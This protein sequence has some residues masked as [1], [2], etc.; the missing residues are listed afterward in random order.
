MTRVYSDIIS[1]IDS[2]RHTLAVYLDLSSAF[3]SI[4]HSILLEELHS[5]GIR[6]KALE[7]LRSYLSDRLV[8]V[9][10][11]GKRSEPLPLKYGVPQGSVLG[12]VLFVLYTRRLSAIL[13]DLG[14]DH[15]IYADDTQFYCSFNDDEIPHIKE[16]VTEALRTIQTWMCSMKLKLN[17]SKTSF[18]I[19]SP[20]HKR[21]FITEHFGDL[22]IGDIRLS[23]SSQVKTLGVTLDSELT[24]IP[25]IDNVIRSCNFAIHNL[26]VA[27]E[28]LTRDV[29][30]QTVTHEVFSRLD[31]CNSLFLC[32]PKN[33]LQR[34]QKVINSCAKLVF[35]APRTAHVTPMLRSLHWLPIGPRIDH[36]VLTLTYKAISHGQPS[37]LA[38]LLQPT[39]RGLL[40]QR[41][42]PGGHRVADRSFTHSAPSLFNKLPPT[43]RA[44]PSA[45]AFKR[46]LKAFLF[47]DAYDHKLDSLLTYA[48]SHDFMIRRA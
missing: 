24:L 1:N 30:I 19:F 2:N 23:P 22:V 41:S 45:D 42:A 44:S 43:L 36:K 10:I 28:F 40:R 18:M 27:K 46:S 48:P 11:D 37:Y 17:M 21:Q 31:Y 14:L 39:G 4:D 6:G 15:H 25:H 12:P 20:K 7:T 32:L 35:G 13:T 47:A 29:L 33:Q 38:E 8:Q 5:A 16:K 3:D 9:A 34:L 26:Y